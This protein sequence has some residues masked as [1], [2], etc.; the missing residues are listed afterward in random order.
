MKTIETL[1]KELDEIRI[2]SRQ[3]K[4]Q[5]G[6]FGILAC[7]E[8]I[9]WNEQVLKESLG[10]QY[11]ELVQRGLHEVGFNLHMIVACEELIFERGAR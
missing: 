8:A 9:R 6:T 11:V 7:K 5:T 4:L 1:N 2:K 10:E 3:G